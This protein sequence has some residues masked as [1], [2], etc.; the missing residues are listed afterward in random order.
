MN[1]LDEREISLIDLIYYLLRRYRSI[2][3]M[4]VIG[5]LLVTSGAFIKTKYLTSEGDFLKYEQDLLV[6]NTD[7]RLLS[8]YEDNLK[9]EQSALVDNPLITIPSHNLPT[10]SISLCIEQSYSEPLN[11]TNYYDPGDSIID[12]VE[13]TITKSSNWEQLAQKYEINK[14][15]MK[16]LININPSYESNIVT[17][18]AYGKD[19]DTAS[20]LL[21]DIVDVVENNM[22]EIL[23]S[24]RGYYITKRNN[25]TYI[26]NTWVNNI[27]ETIQGNINNYIS[28]INTIKNK[29]KDS[30]EPETPDYFSIKD[31]IK[32]SVIGAFVGLVIMAG[33]YCVIYMLNDFIR[34]ED[35]IHSYFGFS[36]LGTFAVKDD[37]PKSNKLD[38]FL[39]KKQYGD[40][41]DEFVVNRIAEN[42]NLLSKEDNKIL[43][44]GNID[45]TV[46][47]NLF[48]QLSTK[49][50]KGKLILGGNINKD[51]QALTKL[52]NA[53]SII[54][55]EKRN[56]S[57]MKDILKEAEIVKNC[58][59]QVIGYIQ[60]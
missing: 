47:N 24:Y 18:E 13:L 30:G 46:L 27:E 52:S 42:I 7:Q 39:L 26:D 15:Y 31:G 36:N 34:E 59:K 28:Q 43:L 4:M 37:N 17:I 44:I 21:N 25:T 54:L 35:E 9:E 22:D 41:D 3:L 23:N 29:Y 16:D 50:N 10:A 56:S 11:S 5:A 53:D 51:N 12:N 48:N 20:E 33:I 57:K 19:L 6:Y 32:Y 14:K 49:V 2:L 45:D 60:I 58:N 55:L 1:D 8:I 38:K 40:L